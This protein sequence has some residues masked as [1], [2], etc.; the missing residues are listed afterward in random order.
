M[1]L[2]WSY[3]RTGKSKQRN[4]DFFMR[5]VCLGDS[6]TYGFGL[7]RGQDWVSLAALATGHELIN[8]GVCGDTTGGMLARL[9]TGVLELKAEAVV[10]MGGTNDILTSGSDAAA[11]NNMAA[12]VQQALSAGVAPIVGIPIPA[13]PP[14]VREEW[15]KLADFDDANRVLFSYSEW[16]K[17]YCDVFNVPVVDFSGIFI[18]DGHI[19]GELYFD[20]LHPNAIGNDAMAKLL[21]EKL[22]ELGF[23][24]DKAEE[25]KK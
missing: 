12:I 23:A 17:K 10:I 11:R 1:V 9:A 5:I 13:D 4:G 25:D 22:Q 18:K 8:K 3:H 6:L 24:A 15:L 20:G 14:R 2:F 19:R 16:L 21:R 7:R